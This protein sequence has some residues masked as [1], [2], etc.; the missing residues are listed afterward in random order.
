[1]GMQYKHVS[2]CLY[3]WLYV[4]MSVSLSIPLPLCLQGIGGVYLSWTLVHITALQG[5]I[6]MTDSDFQLSSSPA[7]D[8][9]APG[10][11]GG[12]GTGEAWSGLEK[13]GVFWYILPSLCHSETKLQRVKSARLWQREIK[14]VHII[15]TFIHRCAHKNMH[16]HIMHACLHRWT[17][18]I[19][20]TKTQRIHWTETVASCQIQGHAVWMD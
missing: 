4:R 9:E 11:Q 16:T 18:R 8:C 5:M 10:M 7:G 15:H 14:W 1:M 2:V 12:R 3:V 19:E 6:L 13:A 20:N 17:E